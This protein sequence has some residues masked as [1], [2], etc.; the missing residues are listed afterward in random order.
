[1]Q[2]HTHITNQSTVLVSSY[3][4][5][6]IRIDVDWVW[7]HAAGPDSNCTTAFSRCSLRAVGIHQKNP[8]FTLP[9]CCRRPIGLC[10]Q[11]GRQPVSLRL[12]AQITFLTW[13]VVEK[14]I[15]RAKRHR[16]LKAVY[17][18]TRV[19]KL[20]F[21]TF[22]EYLT[23]NTSSTQFQSEGEDSRALSI[24]LFMCLL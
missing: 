21:Q 22:L 20:L 15:T 4:Y 12:E 16:T 23:Q 19:R 7:S 24:V 11:L 10:H 14:K 6:G 18:M 3:K 1:M 17:D 2:T 8:A 13:R 9:R 5:L